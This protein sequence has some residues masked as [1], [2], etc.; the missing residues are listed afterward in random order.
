MDGPK[1]GED[2]DSIFDRSFDKFLGL[3]FDILDDHGHDFE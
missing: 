2:K 1:V 3:K